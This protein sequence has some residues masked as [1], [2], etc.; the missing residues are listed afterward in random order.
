[1]KNSKSAARATELAL[2]AMIGVTVLF[3]SDSVAADS[4]FYIGGSYGMSRINNSDF[5]DNTNILK[6]FAGGKFGDFIGVEAA[7]LDYG[8]AND[9]DLKS[10][11]TG[12]SVA[13]V[14]FL[15]FTDSFEGFIKL[16]NLWWENDIR[17]LG[18]K[19]SQDG[20]EL[21]YGGGFSFYFNKTLVMR[22]ELE[23]YTVE[24][25]SDEVGID[26]DGDTDVD[27]ASVGVVFNF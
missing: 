25:S 22:F 9:N 21:F 5:D 7:A 2:A 8:S 26:I 1:M 11:L 24:L 18:F 3:A 16:G 23:R 17:F 20:E 14:G 10:D 19:D 6:A 15:P 4:A 13:L 27:V 12:A